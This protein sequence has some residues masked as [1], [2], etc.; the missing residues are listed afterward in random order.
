MGRVLNISPENRGLILVT[1]QVL[2]ASKYE[3]LA[4]KAREGNW[5]AEPP[6]VL[7]E[8]PDS[9]KGGFR[10][11]L[12]NGAHRL[13]VASEGS[14]ELRGLVVNNASEI[15]SREAIRAPRED[16]PRVWTPNERLEAGLRVCLGS[17]LE[18]VQP[19]SWKKFR[20]TQYDLAALLQELQ[21]QEEAGLLESLTTIS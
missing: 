12:Y 20:N 17:N 16:E 19:G 13:I 11:H 8:M 10:F 4:V 3:K 2:L 7:S 15:P 21:A 9:Y 6:V 14:L 1:Q 5:R 18:N